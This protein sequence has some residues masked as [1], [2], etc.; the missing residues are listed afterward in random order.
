MAYTSS[1]STRRQSFSASRRAELAAAVLRMWADQM[2]ARGDIGWRTTRAESS[3]GWSSREV[4]LC[5]ALRA[6]RE[7]WRNMTCVGL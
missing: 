7:S 5:G 3:F 4:K 6:W 1:K 2:R